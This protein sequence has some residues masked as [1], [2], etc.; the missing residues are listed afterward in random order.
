MTLVGR[1]TCAEDML[2]STYVGYQENVRG[3]SVLQ[4]ERFFKN[5]PWRLRMLE[6]IVIRVMSLGGNWVGYVKKEDK[7]MK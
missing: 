6:K 4:R 7:A 5:T 1:L 3:G 2:A